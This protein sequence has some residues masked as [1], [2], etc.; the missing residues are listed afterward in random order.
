MQQPKESLASVYPRRSI[1]INAQILLAAALFVVGVSAPILT[2]KTLVFFKNTVSIITGLYGLALDGQLLLFAIIAVFS[3]LLPIVKL[4]LL[5]RLWN[6]GH[7]DRAHYR[8]YLHWLAQ[9]G[10]WSMLDVFVVALMVVIVKLGAIGKVQV[11]FGL[12][13][14]AASV[15]LTMLVTAQ[16]VHF[17]KGELRVARVE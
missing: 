14:F 16:V 4:V 9:Y 13:A 15:L 2:L 5:F 1:W 10:K 3:L 7:H 17:A 11:H 12:Y 6:G 8:K